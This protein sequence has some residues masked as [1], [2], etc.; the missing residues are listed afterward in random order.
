[1][2]DLADLMDDLSR[3]LDQSHVLSLDLAI[4]LGFSSKI[5]DLPLGVQLQRFCVGKRIFHPLLPKS[6]PFRVDGYREIG[7]RVDESLKNVRT[8]HDVRIT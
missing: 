8:V 1:M 4:R 7:L 2:I 5:D 6:P 3:N